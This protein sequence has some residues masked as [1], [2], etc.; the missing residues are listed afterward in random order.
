MSVNTFLV[1]R[2]YNSKWPTTEMTSY[3]VSWLVGW[4]VVYSVDGR[5]YRTKV[6][7]EM[8]F[9]VEGQKWILVFP[10]RINLHSIHKIAGND[11]GF[12]QFVYNSQNIENL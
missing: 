6:V 1:C 2:L 3:I 4:L 12:L 10:S 8:G 11:T 7:N 5:S 9:Q